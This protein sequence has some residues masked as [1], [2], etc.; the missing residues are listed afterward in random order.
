MELVLDY[1]SP[2][3][4]SSPTTSPSP[5][6]PRLQLSMLFVFPTLGCEHRMSFCASAQTPGW[7]HKG[8]AVAVVWCGV[9]CH[10]SNHYTGIRYAND[11]T[12]LIHPRSRLKVLI[13]ICEQY[14]DDY[15]VKFNSAKSMYLVFRGQK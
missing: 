11:L 8:T 10:M 1:S 9:G 13:E 4:F 7:C 14:A 15:C 2:S 5:V 3:P 12:L 6:V